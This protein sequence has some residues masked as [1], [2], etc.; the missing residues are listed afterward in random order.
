MNRQTRC[1][2]ARLM[3]KEE[4]CCGAV[5]GTTILCTAVPRPATS[6]RGRS[7]TMFTRSL[8]FVLSALLGGLIG[9]HLY[10]SPLAL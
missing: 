9:S 4:S 8:V 6:S 7:A 1:R 5:P 3:R 10:F 2:F